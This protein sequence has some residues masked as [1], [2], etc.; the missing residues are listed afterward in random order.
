MSYRRPPGTALSFVVICKVFVSF[1]FAC[2]IS[3]LARVPLSTA[4]P[5]IEDISQ[6]AKMAS[7]PIE[8]QRKRLNTLKRT[9]YSGIVITERIYVAT[10]LALN[11]EK[12]DEIC[13]RFLEAKE[14]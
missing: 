11:Q 3:F 6:R 8:E 1:I 10:K 9:F 13:Y 12:Y 2:V 4:P 7:P 5:L 14:M